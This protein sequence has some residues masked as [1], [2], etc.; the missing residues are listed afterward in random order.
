MDFILLE[1]GGM[2]LFKKDLDTVFLQRIIKDAISASE[3]IY[4]KIK[5]S[6]I[7]IIVFVQKC[8]LW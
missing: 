2:F 6:Q 3:E 5:T 4:Y 1:S 8:Q 7:L